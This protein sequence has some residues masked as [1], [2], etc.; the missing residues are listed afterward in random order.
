MQKPAAGSSATASSLFE[1]LLPPQAISLRNADGMGARRGC[2]LIAV[3][4]SMAATRYRPWTP[5]GTPVIR[6]SGAPWHTRGEVVASSGIAN[7]AGR[8]HL[9]ALDLVRG[10][11]AILVCISHWRNLLFVPFGQVHSLPLAPLYLVTSCGHEAVVIFFVLSGYLVGGSAL[12]SI[13]NGKFSWARYAVHRTVRLEVVLIPGLILCA[14]CDWSGIALGRAPDL[15]AGLS[16]NAV[17][18]NVHATLTGD[19]FI[20]NVLFLQQ[21]TVPTF[22]SDGAL[23][24]LS[25]EFWY[26]LLFPALAS[27]ALS[28][29]SPLFRITCFI[30]AVAILALIPL[31]FTLS[32]PI[33]LAGAALAAAFE[34]IP[35]AS[36]FIRRAACICYSVIF[37]A[38]SKPELFPSAFRPMLKGTGGDYVLAILTVVLLWAILS[39]ATRFGASLL[40]V[41]RA[42]ADFSYTLYVVHIPF[43]T[44]AASIFVGFGRWNP[45]ATHLAIALTI[46]A[47]TLGYARLVASFTEMRTHEIRS[48]CERKL[49]P[50]LPRTAADST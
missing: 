35:P 2:P 4:V 11:A 30:V 15:Y 50:A 23:W 21:I 28:N 42:T 19:A 44:L 1:G 27:A 26:Y 25:Y 43:L 7:S 32:F 46:L 39:G 34:R 40:R 31:S 38:L 41:T 12:K 37:L 5:R 3:V 17:T 33:W 18:G 47:F 45:D 16:G 13:R 22:G 49:L 10:I 14:L 9:E 20:G 24:S 6:V 36:P 29:A 8:G 48:W